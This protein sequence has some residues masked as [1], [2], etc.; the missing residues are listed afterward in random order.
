MFS[1]SNPTTFTNCRSVFDRVTTISA[2]FSQAVQRSHD[3]RNALM[4]LQSTRPTTTKAH[5]VVNIVTCRVPKMHGSICKWRKATRLLPGRHQRQ[6]ERRMKYWSCHCEPFC[7]LW[8]W[9]ILQLAHLSTSFLCSA[10]NSG[11]FIFRPLL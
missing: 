1:I 8:S 2:P 3:I 10:L 9:R 6:G 7:R 4:N 5:K 11:Y